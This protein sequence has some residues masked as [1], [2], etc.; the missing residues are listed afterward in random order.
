MVTM[1]FL[2]YNWSNYVILFKY[3]DRLLTPQNAA[4]NAPVYESKISIRSV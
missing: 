4:I 1:N 2:L 3:S